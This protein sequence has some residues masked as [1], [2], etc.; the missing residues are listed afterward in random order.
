[1]LRAFPLLILP[2]LTVA[3]A[4]HVVG[5]PAGDGGD[6]AASKDVDHGDAVYCNVGLNPG[7]C[8][9]GDDCVLLQGQM[10]QWSD[11]CPPGQDASSHYCYSPGP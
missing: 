5:E 8:L 11:C 7:Y 3:C 6:A 10:Y 1:M 4:A 2:V 9:P